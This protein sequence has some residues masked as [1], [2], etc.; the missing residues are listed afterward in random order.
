MTDDLGLKLVYK[1]VVQCNF[2]ALYEFD[3]V[4][5]SLQSLLVSTLELLFAGG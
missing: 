5:G 4:I 3:W 2:Q 1:P